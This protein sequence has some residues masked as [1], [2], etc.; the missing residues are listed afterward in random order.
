MSSS[1]DATRRFQHLFA[2]CRASLDFGNCLDARLCSLCHSRKAFVGISAIRWER[3]RHAKTD[4]EEMRT[5]TMRTIQQLGF[6]CKLLEEGTLPV[7]KTPQPCTRNDTF[8]PQ[9]PTRGDLVY[10]SL[11][12]PGNPSYLLYCLSSGV[13]KRVHFLG[14]M[15]SASVPVN[16]I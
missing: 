6:L 8:E 2:C 9:A 7:A 4:V 5:V 16:S 10:K 12:S 15:N 13:T 1:K 14:L 3:L 11:A